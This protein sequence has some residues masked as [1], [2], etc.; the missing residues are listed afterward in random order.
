MSPTLAKEAHAAT[1]NL[2]N[3]LF[4]SFQVDILHP[5][6]SLHWG[7]FGG[8]RTE[9]KSWIQCVSLKNKVFISIEETT[10]LVLLETSTDFDYKIVHRVGHNNIIIPLVHGYSLAVYRSQLLL[11]GG[12][13]QF[14]GIW[15]SHATLITFRP[16]LLPPMPTP[17]RCASAVNTGNPECLVVA[18]GYSGSVK[19]NVV[20]VLI[21]KQWYT[22]QPLPSFYGGIN[23]T[24]HDGEIYF[25]AQ[26][27]IYHCEV[28]S[29]MVSCTQS[30]DNNIH[31]LKPAPNPSALQKTLPLM[32]VSLGQRL[33]NVDTP[34]SQ[35]YSPLT[36]SWWHIDEFA[37][38]NMSEIICSAVL[39]TGDLFVIM[40]S[41]ICI[42]TL[43]IASLRGELYC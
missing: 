40:Q 17:R 10:K 6:A 21:E 14:N 8:L 5:L 28:E 26:D 41:A 25:S 31:S 3:W 12:N 42:S 23:C 24:V 34:S 16:S 20:E 43:C 2:L 35:A 18:G 29:L 37:T 36:R 7:S 27:A 38:E 39:P 11:I 19:V 4:V 15:T 9:E 13:D 33:V 22:V 1:R 32:L 30:S